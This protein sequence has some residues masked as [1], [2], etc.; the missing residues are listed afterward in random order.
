MY[1]RSSLEMQGLILSSPTDSSTQSTKHIISSHHLS[2]LS[3]F[4]Q[5]WL[6][7]PPLASLF[8]L[9]APILTQILTLNS[10]LALALSS[11]TPSAPPCILSKSIIIITTIITS[12][13]LLVVD[14]KSIIRVENPVVLGG[15]C[16]C[17]M[18]SRAPLRGVRNT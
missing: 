11:P 6:P 5:P 13:P 15:I 9:Q 18:L 10:P 8:L 7:S 17:R 2:I 4:P 1:W 3:L 14:A 16:C 12:V